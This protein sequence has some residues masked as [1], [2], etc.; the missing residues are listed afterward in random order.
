MVYE[1]KCIVS[2]SFAYLML[3]IEHTN[4]SFDGRS[5][6]PSIVPASSLLRVFSPIPGSRILSVEMR[7]KVMR[8]AATATS[9]VITLVASIGCQQ[10]MTL[11]FDEG[12]RLMCFVSK[13]YVCFHFF[14]VFS[15]FT[16]VLCFR[17][18]VWLLA[19]VIHSENLLRVSL[20]LWRYLIVSYISQIYHVLAISYLDCGW[21]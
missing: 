16:E 11:Y 21:C 4:W 19:A 1:C 13:H 9:A 10:F 15:Y 7:F 3:R 12:V 17:H 2:E 18:C 6:R 20:Y 14:R 8:T 5:N